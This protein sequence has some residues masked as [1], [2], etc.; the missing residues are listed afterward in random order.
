MMNY[1]KSILLLG[2]VSVFLFSSCNDDDDPND[3]TFII[4][5]NIN[6]DG[7]PILLDSM[8]YVN[9][10]NNTYSI[11][12]FKAAISRIH[13]HKEGT[14]EIN[15]KDEHLIDI[16]D[17]SSITIYEGTLAGGDYETIHF[18]FGLDENMNIP[19]AYP[20]LPFSNFEWPMMLGG[21][22]HYMQ[23]DGFYN[24]STGMDPY[25]THAGPT[26]GNLNYSSFDFPVDFE[27]DGGTT[28]ATIN[29]N[30]NNFYNGPNAWDF[31]VV[32]TA[33]MPDQTWQVKLKE[34]AQDVF[35]VSVE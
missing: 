25:N 19:G 21:G 27:I 29:I 16:T 10:S 18:I 8:M 26:N 22:Y 14:G 30:L 17:A 32:P 20:N 28:T 4:V 13:V 3:G 31:S 34:N 15:L 33:I 35:S 23:L 2:L 9:A 1:F 6:I 5:A 24:G 11:A 7:Q 12:R